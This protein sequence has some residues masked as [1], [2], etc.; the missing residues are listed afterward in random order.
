MEVRHITRSSS[1]THHPKAYTGAN[2]EF[3]ISNSPVRED[4]GCSNFVAICSNCTPDFMCLRSAV[5]GVLCHNGPL[6]CVNLVGA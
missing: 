4:V 5:A 6:S 2:F 3:K 1:A